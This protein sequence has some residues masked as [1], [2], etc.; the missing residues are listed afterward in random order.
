MEYQALRKAST[1]GV[2]KFIY[3]V[4]IASVGYPLLIVNN[5]GPENQALT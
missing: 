3:E 4:Y 5:E 1:R 2:T